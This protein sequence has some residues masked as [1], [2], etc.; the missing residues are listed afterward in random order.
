[1]SAAVQQIRREDGTAWGAAATVSS[2]DSAPSGGSAGSAVAAGA[3]VV[4]WQ[5]H[6][7]S[8]ITDYAITVWGY[9]NSQWSIVEEFLNQGAS[10]RIGETWIGALKATRWAVTV[11][12]LTGTSLKIQKRQ[13]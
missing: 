7:L 1:M 13:I 5:T 2:A 4:Q 9:V 3:Q 10:A 8:A 12:V 6:T 11:S